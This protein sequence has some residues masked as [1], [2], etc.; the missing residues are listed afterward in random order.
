MAGSASFNPAENPVNQI[1]AGQLVFDIDC[2]PPPPAE[3]L[4]FN[5]FIDTTLLSQ[6]TGNAN[7]RMNAAMLA[8]QVIA[9]MWTDPTNLAGYATGGA[10]YTT[11]SKTLS[12]SSATASTSCLPR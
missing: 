10:Q 11:W 5:V 1:A 3:R 9:Q 2:M 6:L 7:Y 8:D 4:T 12:C